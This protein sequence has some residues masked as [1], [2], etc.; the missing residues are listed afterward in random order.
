VHAGVLAL[1][2]MATAPSGH[3]PLRLEL[4]QCADIDRVIVSRVVTVELGAALADEGQAGALTTAK[5]ECSGENVSLNIDDPVTG[6]SSTRAMSLAGQPRS[7]RSRLLG[8]AISEAVLAS[9]VELHLAPESTWSPSLTA[10]SLQTRREA[11]DIAERRL[12]ATVRAPAEPRS[13][14]AAGPSLRWFSSGL[15]MLGLSAGAKH[16]L[17]RLPSAGVGL[18]LDVGYGTHTVPGVARAS[19]TSGSLA[20]CLLV[21]AT[22]A[23]VVVTAG[24]GFRLGLARLSAEPESSLRWGRASLRVWT[25]PFLAIDV[26]VLLGRSIF[27]RAQAESGYAV[28]AARGRVDS[29][30][31]IGMEGSW[32]GT[33]LSL[34]TRY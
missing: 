13:E 9:W 31:V 4:E 25:G 19:A 32:L 29:Y 22:L 24:A 27:V 11:A 7:F 6:K 3:A 26:S 20:P 10:A 21:R 2:A 8:L 14:I 1:L 12:Q 30:Q 16:W 33:V 15:R 18:D 17:K 28:V 23:R 34:G 5:V